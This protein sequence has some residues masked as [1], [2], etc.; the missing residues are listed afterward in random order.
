MSGEGR[1]VVSLGE[2][3]GDGRDRVMMSL[4]H[5]SHS[6]CFLL[7]SK[8]CSGLFLL[9]RGSDV[10]FGFGSG[11]GSVLAS[12]VVALTFI[13]AKVIVPIVFI[14]GFATESFRDGTGELTDDLLEAAGDPDPRGV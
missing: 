1:G 9:T 11:I 14:T 7:S 13:S 3:E 6:F 2:G 8:G 5:L 12:L 4:S 10:G